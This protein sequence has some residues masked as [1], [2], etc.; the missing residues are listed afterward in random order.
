LIYLLDTNVVADLAAN[1]RLIW[2][3]FDQSFE[4]GDSIGLCQPVLYEVRR[5]FFWRQS[6]TKATVFERQILLHL[7]LFPLTDADW[8][9]AARF[10]AEAVRNGKQLSDVDLLLAALAQRL[11]A[12]LVSSDEDFAILPV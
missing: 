1:V 9:Q 4:A 3:R 10:W 11:D 7:T 6:P 8:L 2:Q 5:G 12:T